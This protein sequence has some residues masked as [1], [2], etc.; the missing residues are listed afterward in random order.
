MANKKS[1]KK[2]NKK[3]DQ[4]SLAG[5]K[6]AVILIVTV[7]AVTVFGSLIQ[8]GMHHFFYPQKEFV[9]PSAIGLLIYDIEKS[10]YEVVQIEGYAY[11]LHYLFKN[12]EDAVE[13][14][15]YINEQSIFGDKP[16][17][18]K[19]WRGFYT[20][21][22]DKDA[23]YSDMLHI[24][25]DDNPLCHTM[26]ITKDAGKMLCGVTMDSRISARSDVPEG[27]EALLVMPAENIEDAKALIEEAAADS[28]NMREWLI[29]NGWIVE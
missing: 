22:H 29:E 28:E 9:M 26:I 3:S 21:F 11:K 5:V 7:I 18:E 14:N 25:G 16:V 23:Q 10:D 13:G 8:Y 27:T 6:K 19:E 1:D 2:S 20:E 12:R 17:S 24:S 15:F 4:G